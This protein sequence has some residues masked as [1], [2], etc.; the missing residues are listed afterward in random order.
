MNY[1]RQLARAS[2]DG[3]RDTLMA[4]KN[5]PRPTHGWIATIRFALGISQPLL[6]ARMGTSKQRIS[7]LER[8]EREGTI[9]LSQ[10]KDVADHLGCDLVYA[11]VPRNAS[12]RR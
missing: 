12:S 3:R 7:Q 5:Y 8:R 11:L 2:I 10:L 4:L 1:N 9:Q 6:G